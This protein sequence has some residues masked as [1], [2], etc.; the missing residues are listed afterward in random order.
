MLL[1]TLISVVLGV[2]FA[3]V[4]ALASVVFINW[5]IPYVRWAEELLRAYMEHQEGS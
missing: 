4:V 5:A 2:A 1:I 3:I